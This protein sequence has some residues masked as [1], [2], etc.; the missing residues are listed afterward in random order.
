MASKVPTRGK[1][2][3]SD[4]QA[5]RLMRANLDDP[6][7]K[8]PQ[9]VDG[10]DFE[11]FAGVLGFAAGKPPSDAKTVKEIQK[12]MG[13]GENTVRRAL[14]AKVAS[15]EM[16]CGKFRRHDP[17]KNHTSLLMYYWFAKKKRV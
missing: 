6:K 14:E 4:S 7:G 10:F 2:D 12:R 9:G 16:E 1:P 15:G 17:T 13:L 11:R 3:I 5:L 8:N